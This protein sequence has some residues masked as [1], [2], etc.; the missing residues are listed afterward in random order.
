MPYKITIL[1]ENDF[2]KKVIHNQAADQEGRVTY[3][4]RRDRSA[5]IKHHFRFINDMPL[6]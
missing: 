4:E 1:G 3:Y 5:R 2:A 6:N